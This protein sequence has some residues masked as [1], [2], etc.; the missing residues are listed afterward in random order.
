MSQNYQIC[1]RCVMDTSDPEIVFD[2]HGVCNNCQQA[3][4]RINSY[5]LNLDIETRK[6]Q[7][8]EQVKIIKKKVKIKNMIVLLV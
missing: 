8:L 6:K 2:E 5:P 7:L 4:N 1:K 3:L